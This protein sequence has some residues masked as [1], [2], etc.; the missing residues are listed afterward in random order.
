VAKSKIL[1]RR[2]TPAVANSS[3]SRSNSILRIKWKSL[4]F[5]RQRCRYSTR[6]T[7]PQQT[8]NNLKRINQQKMNLFYASS[9]SVATLFI[10]LLSSP[11]FPMHFS[12]FHPKAQN[13]TNLFHETGLQHIL[14][15]QMTN[16]LWHKYNPDVIPRDYV[17]SMK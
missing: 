13:I 12:H 16:K 5:Q 11:V 8:I 2:E 7:H 1:M 9:S 14:D 17:G 10:I 6:N 15:I 3:S 4:H